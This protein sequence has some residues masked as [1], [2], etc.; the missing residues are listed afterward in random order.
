MNTLGT[1]SIFIG[2][3]LTVLFTKII[4][5]EFSILN[6]HFTREGNGSHSL[7]NWEKENNEKNA[8]LNKIPHITI[9]STK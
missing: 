6:W 7:S 1:I 4:S 5:T 3:L 8:I 2:I 9:S